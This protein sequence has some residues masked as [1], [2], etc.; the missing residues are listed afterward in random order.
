MKELNKKLQERLNEMVL[1]GHL[2]RS[3]VS[4][5]QI[6][7]AYLEGFGKDPV[8]RDPSSSVHNCNLC[9]NVTAL[10]QYIFYFFHHCPADYNL[11]ALR[12]FHTGNVFNNNNTL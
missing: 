5:E 4:G 10:F 7:N 9:H 11:S 1:T 6:W 3:T 12:A 2:F 8:Y